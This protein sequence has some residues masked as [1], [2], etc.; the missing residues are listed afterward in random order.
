M[1]TCI[2]SKSCKSSKSETSKSKTSDAKAKKVSGE[3]GSTKTAKKES[4]MSMNTKS[5]KTTDSGGG[6]GSLSKSKGSKGASSIEDTTSKLEALPV[7]DS[8][9]SN[10]NSSPSNLA[11]IVSAAAVALV[12]VVG[13]MFFMERR[14]NGGVGTRRQRRRMHHHDDESEPSHYDLDSLVEE[15][16]RSLADTL[17]AEGKTKKSIVVPPGQ[18]E[19]DVFDVDEEIKDA[20]DQKDNRDYSGYPMPSALMNMMASL[21]PRMASLNNARETSLIDNVSITVRS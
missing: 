11:W 2:G 15:E 20:L 14:S 8:S 6:G 1:P 18:D 10:L 3:S 19:E 4:S 16:V 12:A 13:G 17:E 7:S 9:N 5:S 21:S